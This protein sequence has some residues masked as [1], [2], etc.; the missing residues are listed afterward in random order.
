MIT[1]DTLT[2]GPRGRRLLLSYALA[3]EEAT[4]P[5]YSD[6]SFRSAVF[7]ASYHLDP[8]RGTSRVMFGPGA[9]EARQT[10]ITPEEVA[11]R[12]SEVALP[13]V[14]ATSLRFALVDAVDTA[15]YWQEPEGED[16]LV[17]TEPMRRELRRIAEHIA[18][19]PHVQWWATTLVDTEQW[20][21]G[22]NDPHAV[23]AGKQTRSIPAVA[24]QLCTWREET[25]ESE[26]RAQRTRPLDPAANFSGWWW[27]NPSVPSTARA[28]FDGTP[29]EL[30]FVEDSMG[31]TSGAARRVNTLPDAPV[32]EIYEPGAWADLCRRFPLEVSAEK[33]Q[34]WYRTTGR[35]GRWVIPDWTQVA[36]DYAGVHLTVAGYL[37]AA[38]TAIDVDTD[39][40]SVIAG[41][42][43]DTTFWLTDVGFDDDSVTWL[44][45]ESQN[46]LAWSREA[47]Q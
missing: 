45:D 42:G 33:R 34:D 29:A 35:A 6:D 43:P 11:R 44:L 23:D 12:L 37:S 16:I 25:V 28:L 15:R 7:L 41:W 2:V 46:Q 47:R 20:S 40:A 27:S 13:E 21:V 14:T 9:E 1:A 26:A 32:Y 18:R 3:A 10:V 30:W 5:E 38:G 8:D 17:A 22:W 24:Q 39:T 31:W 36:N 4:R 19:S